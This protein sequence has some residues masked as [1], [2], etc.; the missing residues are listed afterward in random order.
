MLS[1][2]HKAI[3][4]LAESHSDQ[5]NATNST[6]DKAIMYVRQAVNEEVPRE[7]RHDGNL[8]DVRSN[9][10]DDIKQAVENLCATEPNPLVSKFVMSV[11]F[12]AIEVRH[13][14]N[15]VNAGICDLPDP[16]GK[17]F[18][19]GAKSP[20]QCTDARKFRATAG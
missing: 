2:R 4:D 17:E 9:N 10:L 11:C 13:K 20:R 16:S 1:T 14:L 8:L 3:A 19:A 7:S 18:W 15:Q 6:L 12:D 5:K